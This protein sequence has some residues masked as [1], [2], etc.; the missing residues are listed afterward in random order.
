MT[1]ALIALGASLANKARLT[2]SICAKPI[3]F[4]TWNMTGQNRPIFSPAGVIAAAVNR[5]NMPAT[6]KAEPM[7]ILPSSSGSF[8]LLPYQR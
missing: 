8:R 1:V 4:R 5:H 7:M 2:G 3:E 6:E